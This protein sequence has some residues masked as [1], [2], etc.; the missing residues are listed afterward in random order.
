MSQESKD[1]AANAGVTA[2]WKMGGANFGASANASYATHNSKEES[3]RQAVTEA[4]DITARALDR[5]VTKVK[6]ERIDKVLEEFEE[7]NKHGFDNTKGSSHV[8]GVYRWVDKVVKN[9][10]YNYGKRMMFEFMIPEP[11]KLHTLGVKM[12]DASEKLVKP[13]DPRESSTNKL[14]NFMS[15]SNGILGET[16]LKYWLKTAGWQTE[17]WPCGKQANGEFVK[18]YGRGAKQ[19]SYHYNYGPFSQAMFGDAKVLLNNPDQ[20]AESWLN[21]AS[22]VFFFVYPQA[23]K[24]SMLH[25]ID[26]TW[27]PNSADQSAGIEPGFGATI[28]VINGGLECN[29][30]SEKPQAVNRIAYYKQFTNYLNVPIGANEKL[31]CA[32]MG[33]FTTAGAG[34]M[35]I[36]WDQD[37]SHNA[38]NPGG[39]AFA[40]KQVGYQTAY[41]ALVTGD[42]QKCVAKY[43]DV[44]QVK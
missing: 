17:M 14:E 36:Y 9:Q 11:A 15:L 32:S 21:V 41:N 35:L 4:K 3:N 31:G 33:P 5:I 40:C 22:A 37:W 12:I 18:Y 28:N 2:D 43:F 1:F 27:V 26:G 16:I 38:A 7:N 20:V 42:Y 39:G 34:A 10:I 23:P 24:P 30:G 25:V 8:V 44:R 6:E 13:V 19:L 29:S